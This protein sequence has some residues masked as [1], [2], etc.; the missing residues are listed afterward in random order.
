MIGYRSLGH[1]R[2]MRNEVWGAEGG[3]A[4]ARL[5]PHARMVL[6]SI[7]P[8]GESG[9]ISRTVM[10]AF[11]VLIQHRFPHVRCMTS[12]ASEAVRNR[13]SIRPLVPR[14]ATGKVLLPFDH[15]K[16]HWSLLVFDLDRK[17]YRW[18]DP[19]A[20]DD[21]IVDR[22]VRLTIDAV[23]RA[24]DPENKSAWAQ[25]RERT[26]PPKQTRHR[27]CG[28]FVCMFAAWVGFGL[29]EPWPAIRDPTIE[30]AHIT[31]CLLYERIP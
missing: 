14:A 5:S 8:D 25:T 13:H 29:R 30:R 24:L 19:A 18:I 26:R 2:K 10:D 27:D 7:D 23:V 15:Q 31:G 6:R 11:M 4:V 1:L 17:R 21:Q 9:W 12:R 16:A 28:V 22:D 3:P 20:P